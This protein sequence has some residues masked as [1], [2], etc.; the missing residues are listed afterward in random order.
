MDKPISKGHW[1]GVAEALALGATIGGSVAAEVLGQSALLSAPLSLTLCLS[2]LNRRRLHDAMQ[3]YT[4]QELEQLRQDFYQLDQL[5]L[6]TLKTTNRQ[7]ALPTGMPEMIADIPLITVE[8]ISMS[9]ADPVEPNTLT[10][11]TDSGVLSG[12]LSLE[13]SSALECPEDLLLADAASLEVSC[14]SSLAVSTEQQKSPDPGTTTPQ[15]Q[16]PTQVQPPEFTEQ[17]R[18]DITQ[19]QVTIEQF[20]SQVLP[21]VGALQKQLD[22]VSVQLQ[23]LLEERSQQVL[24]QTIATLEAEINQLHPLDSSTVSESTALDHTVLG[25]GVTS[26]NSTRLQ[27][28]GGGESSVREVSSWIPEDDFPTE[29]FEDLVN[30]IVQLEQPEARHAALN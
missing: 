2:L 25:N 22:R 1:L 24:A 29:E 13:E 23:Q 18:A 19:L 21:N 12:A 28:Y 17:L 4:V 27:S 20:T 7:A 6:A 26:G 15:I 3:Q 14:N 30:A 10:D 16:L 8:P 11:L 9:P 5:M